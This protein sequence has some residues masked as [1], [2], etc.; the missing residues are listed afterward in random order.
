MVYES[1]H[2]KRLQK[3][4]VRVLTEYYDGG[5]TKRRNSDGSAC[6]D[7][8]SGVILDKKYTLDGRDA[9]CETEFNPGILYSFVFPETSDGQLQCP[10]CGAVS[11]RKDFAEGCPYCG[12]ASNLEYAERRAGERDHA[13][14]VVHRPMY[15]IL[16]L[17]L[18]VCIGVGLCLPITLLASRTAFAMDYVKGIFI[19]VF[20]G[21]ALFLLR[22]Y[23]LSKIDIRGYE[24]T[25]QQRQS[26]LLQTFQNDL[27]TAGLSLQAFHNGLSIELD[28]YF[29]GSK[30]PL[31][32]AVVDYDILDFRD[33][34]FS[35]GADKLQI[36][37]DVQLR[38]VS[39]R[40]G[41]LVSESAWW[42]V[43]LQR[44]DK[45]AA[46]QLHE[47]INIIECPNCGAKLS[48][49]N[50]HCLYCG[51]PIAYKRP[52]SLTSIRRIATPEA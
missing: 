6:D 26:R 11:S 44:E 22:Q 40:D 41:E 45:A 32:Q 49:E 18:C 19:G 21:F 33:R 3:T 50:T 52:F 36:C 24:R 10:N 30:D 14:Y 34:H 1:L 51:T 13:D 37:T 28:Q 42:Q 31:L 35:G 4:E 16:R 39:V 9:L 2:A 12:A 17:L 5:T 20:L 47:G 29:Y 46:L 8:I 48:V 38:T 7:V 23:V 15:L 27:A 43:T 25:K